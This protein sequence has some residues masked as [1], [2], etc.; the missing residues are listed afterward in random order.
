[1]KFKFF[2][3]TMFFSFMILNG[4]VSGR[5]QELLKTQDIHKIMQQIISQ[6]AEKNKMTHTVI[7]NSITNYIEDFDPY[8]TYLLESEIYPYLHLSSEELQKIIV[9]YEKS[10]YAVYT[11]LNELFKKSIL[12]ARDSRED[13]GK[14][15]AQF[16]QTAL[17]FDGHEIEA[18]TLNKNFAEND[19]EL[20]NRIK[21]QLT[22]L[23]QSEKRR[24]GDA[25]VIKNQKSILSTYEKRL[26]A[27]ENQY[28]FNDEKNQPLSKSENENLFAM[29]ILKSLASGLD[30]HTE[31][32]NPTQANDM[33]MHLENTFQGV[34]LTL[35]DSPEGV[36]VGSL[37]PGT[38]AAKSGLIKVNDQIL[39]IDEK[40]ISEMEV[41]KVANL[42][43]GKTNSMVTL[44]LK[45]K[46]V[47]G[48]QV[49]DK[50]L[51]VKLKREAITI[52]E[53]RVMSSFENFGSGII[54]KITLNSFYQ[55]GNAVSSEKD[56]RDALGKLEKSGDLRGLILDLRE[57]TGGFLSQAVKVAGL[58]ITN[59]VIVIS[60]YANGDE[61]F[62]R[63]M[64]GKT[65]YKGPLIVLTSKMTAS[66][67][68]IVAGALQDYGVAVIVG[69]EHTYGKGTVQTQTVT[70]DGAS[71]FFKVT[72]GKYYTVSGKT[73]QIKGVLADV[74]VP[75][76]YSFERV[77]EA[78]LGAN[79]LK[80]DTISSAFNDKL[81]DI[82]ASKKDW[83]LNYYVPTEQQK[84]DFWKLAIPTLKK[85]SQF[86]IIQN[87]N[88]QIFI[89]RL[90][91]E[92]DDQNSDDDSYKTKVVKNFGNEDLQMMEAVNVLKDMIYLETKNLTAEEKIKE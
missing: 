13:L 54:G 38:P 41:G 66:A 67:A 88:Y 17:K 79:T 18:L 33:K 76:K 70:Q 21:N 25:Y 37:L 74:T 3:Q 22:V 40:N 4:I 62:F 36:I 87:K 24:Y 81:Q 92:P 69:D 51:T 44:L 1:M 90:K 46:I 63:D 60:K 43:K 77:G 23:A 82:D 48:N 50:Q 16:F 6:H 73:P 61:R 15:S 71:S 47:E 26:R 32:F 11:K 42:L 45:R 64:D 7:K 5:E 19:A 49:Q 78:Y 68:E 55:N 14:N 84:Q 85:N 91:G 2:F 57:N 34:G 65:F 72:I 30:A 29:H 12:R 39:E 89:K 8:R 83:Y 27:F 53:D 80:N 28:L 35:Q 31:F 58:F 56:V 10:D 86:R 20:K 52:D 75:G 9:Q 59:G